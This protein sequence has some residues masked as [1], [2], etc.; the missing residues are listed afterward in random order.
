MAICLATIAFAGDDKETV[1]ETVTEPV[2]EPVKEPVKERSPVMRKS[3]IYQHTLD[4]TAW[5][6]RYDANSRPM[7]SGTA[8]VIDKN[9]CLL[10][11]NDHVVK[12][13]D[14][15]RV[16]FPA[17]RRGRLMTDGD[18]YKKKEIPLMGWVVDSNPEK[19]L[20]VIRVGALPLATRQLELAA[21][22]DDIQPGEDVFSIGNPGGITDSMWIFTTGT[23]RQV[24][25]T[26]FPVDHDQKINA[27]I[28]E[29]QSPVNPGDSGGPVVNDHGEVVA[30]VSSRDNRTSLRTFFIHVSEI[31]DYMNAVRK[32][33]DPESAEELFE[34]GKNYLAKSRFRQALNDFDEAVGIEPKTA[35]YIVGRGE[36]HFELGDIDAAAKDFSEALKLEPKTEMA[37]CLRGWCYLKK[38]QLKSAKDDFTDALELDS[39]LGRAYAGRA[40]IERENGSKET[41]LEELTT[42]IRHEPA[43]AQY[44]ERR[45]ELN[46]D[47]KKYLNAFQDFTE[48]M[49]LDRSHLGAGRTQLLR[50]RA[51]AARDGGAPHL[52]RVDYNKVIESN[53]ADD[54]AYAGRALAWMKSRM[55]EK[56]IADI[57]AAISRNPKSAMHFVT[58]GN[59]LLVAGRNDES[60]RAYQKAAEINPQV[61]K[62]HRFRDFKSFD[63]RTL[64]VINQTN[65]PIRYH[66]LFQ[67]RSK[68]GKWLW[69]PGE[70][71][72]TEAQD[73]NTWTI[74]PGEFSFPTYVFSEG[75]E[76]RLIGAS[77]VRIWG[78]G[79][80]SGRR[81]NAYR[82]KDFVL[83][84]EGTYKNEEIEPWVYSFSD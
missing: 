75:S 63:R 36:A 7:G 11:T 57:D 80:T 29:S 68:S 34:R 64:V 27:R 82:D 35:K 56:A 47:S 72:T 84:P 58:K 24:L 15:V 62:A 41:A 8:W 31:R 69:Y 48:A 59:I 12:D 18:Y 61:L 46:F 38:G 79:I 39:L 43:V 51:D 67:S 20:A 70:P 77:K 4:G 16:Y 23:V 60:D 13:C 74:E 14:H 55:F 33:I 65:E 81:H 37:L 83:C 21:P 44:H 10:V 71:G 52:A 17:R 30:I 25:T 78:E 54:E 49:R 9:N 22:E 6:V 28:V 1:K 45:G 26:A 3:E 76:P 66:I 40:E 53:D 2:T 50:K 42:A 19:D 5:V 73:V 32:L